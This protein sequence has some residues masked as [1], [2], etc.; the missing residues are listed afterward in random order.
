M[1]GKSGGGGTTTSTTTVPPQVLAAYTSLINQA[2]KVAAAPLQQYQG[3]MLAGFTP[4]QTSAFG[5]INAAQGAANPYI[6]AAANY[7]AQ[8]ATP[9]SGAPVTAQQIQQ[10]ESP[11]T[12]AVT[13]ATE[14][15]F[16]NQNAQ[17]QQQ[18]AGNQITQG[19]Y[20]GDRSAVQAALMAGQQT[21]AEAPVLANIQQQGY[22]QALSEANAQQQA[23]MQAAQLSNQFAGQAASTMGGLGQEALGTQLQGAGAQ[24]QA[25]ELQQNQAQAGLNIPYEQF[26]QQQAYP[27][28]TTGWLGNL[29]EG[30]GSGMGSTGTSQT[31]QSKKARGGRMP[32]YAMGGGMPSPYEREMHQAGGNPSDAALMWR[33]GNPNPYERSLQ[34]S[35]EGPQMS[36]GG[37][38]MSGGGLQMSGRGPQ[39]F[40][41]GLNSV[42]PTGLSGIPS[43]QSPVDPTPARGLNAPHFTR[44]GVQNAGPYDALGTTPYEDLISPSSA[45]PQIG[46]IVPSS[47]SGAAHIAAAPAAPKPPTQQ[48]PLVGAAQDI[49]AAT[50]LYDAGSKIASALSPAASALT[51]LPAGGFGAALS[52]AGSTIN[53]ATGAATASGLGLSAP[54][55]LGAASGL[56]N[57]TPSLASLASAAPQAASA[58]GTGAAASTGLGGTLS[59]IGNGLADAATAAG[60]GILDALAFIGLPVGLADGGHLPHYVAGGATDGDSDDVSVAAPAASVSATNLGS[61]AQNIMPLL[62]QQMLQQQQN[63]AASQV[64]FRHGGLAH[65]ADGGDDSDY[66]SEPD[67]THTSDAADTLVNNLPRAIKATVPA[68]H[69][70]VPIPNVDG[71]L[72]GIGNPPTEAPQGGLSAPAAAPRGGLGVSMP[73]LDI[74][75]YQPA[76]PSL[77]KAIVTGLLSAAGGNSP[78]WGRNLARGALAG[79][80]EY[81]AQESAGTQAAQQKAAVDYA[82]QKE[83]LAY[84][85]QNQTADIKAQ[86]LSDLKKAAAAPSAPAAMDPKVSKAI[87]D[88]HQTAEDPGSSPAQRSLANALIWQLSGGT[89]DPSKYASP[90]PVPKVS[91]IDSLLGA[92]PLVPDAAASAATVSPTIPQMRTSAL[93]EKPAGGTPT[94]PPLDRLLQSTYNP[95]NTLSGVATLPPSTPTTTLPTYLPTG[96]GTAATPPAP[97]ASIAGIQGIRYHPFYGWLVPDASAPGGWSMLGS[98]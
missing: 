84:A 9:I 65:F 43:I 59:A 37:L 80:G 62:M 70:N 22:G 77:T 92:S 42:S 94:L 32:H 25:G 51:P 24:L 40:G 16:A 73:Q 46:Q 36:G 83:A 81:G 4:Q 13:Q 33:H 3:Q 39:I 44:G 2:Q 85:E 60:G 96:R 88:A 8:S 20:G 87:L 69:V 67:D 57:P 30:V 55:N 45:V 91:L 48:N 17:Q 28:Q 41:G 26:M 52:G 74:G 47:I 64:Q 58:A 21:A 90:P 82:N 49:G 1:G 27:F 19:A 11:Y 63:A 12:Q 95:V 10:Y 89:V 72:A 7:A 14:Q 35:E 56:F 75:K 31:S 38:Q 34:M 97:P 76:E 68:E 15:Q 53:P 71:S 50:T 78:F 6:N 5:E 23:A 93:T 66:T 79:M 29:V 98:Q 61:M 86:Q 18:L 54:S